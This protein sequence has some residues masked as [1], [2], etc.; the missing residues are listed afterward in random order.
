MNR[1]PPGGVTFIPN[2][3]FDELMP[4]LRGTDFR[5][6]ILIARSTLGWRNVKT[7][8]RK[9]RDWISHHQL[10]LKTGRSSAAISRAI[11]RLCRLGLIVVEDRAGQ[12]LDS[13]HIRRRH[14]GRLYFYLSPSVVSGEFP[15]DTLKTRLHKVKTTTKD[16]DKDVVVFAND[17]GAK[18]AK[19][20]ND[21]ARQI[22]SDWQQVGEIL[23]GKS[24]RGRGADRL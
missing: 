4:L 8:E 5:L 20:K 10:K 6:L 16:L 9:E 22:Q 14:R 12:L 15:S 11:D 2:F 23:K 1:K 3:I 7:G 18:T 24:Y 17:D 19:S 13:K 21:Q